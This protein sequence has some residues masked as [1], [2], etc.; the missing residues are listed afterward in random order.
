MFHLG[1]TEDVLE[2]YWWDVVDTY[3]WDVLVTHHWDLIGC[4][5]W[6]LFEISWKR[7]DGTSSLCPYETLSWHTNKTSW[8]RTIGTSWWRT[9]ETSLGVSFE[10]C[11][12]R[13]RD[14]LMGRRH[15]VSVRRH[16]DI[17]IWRREV[18]PLRR[19]WVFHLR[20]TCDVTGTYREKSLR[21]CHDV[22]FWQTVFIHYI[23][24]PKSQDKNLNILRTK[25]AKIIG[26][27]K[28]IFHHFSSQKLSQT[29][30]C[31]FKKGFHKIV[32][33]LVE[34]APKFSER[35]WIVTLFFPRSVE[36][37]IMQES[38]VTWVSRKYLWTNHYP[39]IWIAWVKMH[40]VC[41]H[42]AKVNFFTKV[43]VN[44]Q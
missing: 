12:R 27:I 26:E 25:I 42:P 15:Y 38:L 14:V 7:T 43:K 23:T 40:W 16:R 28:N 34:R 5:I 10:T 41:G 3:H 9:T 17:P 31:A 33:D 37:Y 32:S 44:R 36:L 8:R 11:L 13:R 24:W 39:E 22:L 20:C 35:R 30:D 2:T 1:V 29:L 21:R 4:F 6:D 18:V 19:R